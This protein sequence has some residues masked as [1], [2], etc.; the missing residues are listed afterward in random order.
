[1]TEIRGAG[2]LLVLTD[3]PGL[4]RVAALQRRGEYDFEHMRE[5]TYQG[6]LQ[7]TVME[8]AKLVEGRPEG[9]G[10]TMLR[11]VCEELGVRAY[12]FFFNKYVN[13][14]VELVKKEHTLIAAVFMPPKFLE[15]VQLHPSS[16]GFVFMKEE[17]AGEIRAVKHGDENAKKMQYFD[18]NWDYMFADE[19]RALLRAFDRFRNV[20][21]VG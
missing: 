11:G 4:G 2:G 10:A 17:W 5:E 21:A 15:L 16:A 18:P 12:N 14:A 19:K 1:M 20:V 6:L 8:G 9:P 3:L 7:L 13:S